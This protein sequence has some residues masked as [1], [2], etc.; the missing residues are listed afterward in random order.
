VTDF[1]SKRFKVEYSKRNLTFTI[2]LEKNIKNREIKIES[3]SQK[4]KESS[5][6]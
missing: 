3:N 2:A 6:Q 1:V 4:G 5:L